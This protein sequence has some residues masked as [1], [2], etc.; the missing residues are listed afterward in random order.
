MNSD[1]V[2]NRLQP[3]VLPGVVTQYSDELSWHRKLNEYRDRPQRS[4]EPT[5][6]LRAL[7]RFFGVHLE[8]QAE[9]HWIELTPTKSLNLGTPSPFGDLTA[10]GQWKIGTGFGG[11]LST[12]ANPYF[13][14]DVISGILSKTR[15]L[16]ETLASQPS[17][18]DTVSLNEIRTG[19][20]KKSIRAASTWHD[21]DNALRAITRSW[22]CLEKAQRVAEAQTRKL[23]R[24][25]DAPLLV[26][27][28]GWLEERAAKLLEEVQPE[29]RVHPAALESACL[30]IRSC[31]AISPALGSAIDVQRGPLGV[32]LVELEV[33]ESRMLWTVDAP[34]VQWP[35]VQVHAVSLRTENAHV[36]GESRFFFTAKDLVEYFKGA[37][38]RERSNREVY[39]TADSSSIGGESIPS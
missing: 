29:L 17:V 6:K 18:A 21:R 7:N 12:G 15:F 2:A 26:D 37:C 30:I 10:F 22:E 36:K 5:E 16:V 14:H 19:D 32:I 34:R 33:A 28:P 27:P 11:M 35:G 1:Q 38:S 4:V 9:H 20:V 39:S 23:L 3:G 13:T 25:T 24:A 8:S 31:L